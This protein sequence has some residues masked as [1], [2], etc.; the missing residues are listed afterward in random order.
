MENKVKASKRKVVGIIG[1]TGLYHMEGLEKVREQKVDT[2]FGN[3][4]DCYVRC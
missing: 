2:P 1:G 3:P 4:S